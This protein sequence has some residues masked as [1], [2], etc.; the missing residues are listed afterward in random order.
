MNQNSQ[1]EN[2]FKGGIQ[3]GTTAWDKDSLKL[4]GDLHQIAVE[5]REEFPNLDYVFKLSKQQKIDLLGDDCFG[6]SPDG[7]AWF[8]NGKLVAA[9]EA[10]KQGVNGNAIERWWKNASIAECI[11]PDIKYIT[12]CSG[13]GAKKGEVLDKTR[14]LAK[15]IKG[16]NFK[17]FMNA[18]GFDTKKMKTIVKNT[19]ESID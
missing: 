12:F 14:K 8:S 19:L 10:K 11:N 4:D 15:I 13:Q 17:F 5:L 9:F 7:G 2:G 18:D 3:A 16:E 6:F 1:R